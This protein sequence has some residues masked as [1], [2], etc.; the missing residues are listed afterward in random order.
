M[1]PNYISFC[2]FF[3]I[4]LTEFNIFSITEKKNPRISNTMIHL[5]SNLSFKHMELK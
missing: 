5:K 2:S 1:C 3:F 4:L